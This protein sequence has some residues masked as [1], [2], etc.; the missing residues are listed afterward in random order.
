MEV[1]KEVTFTRDKA[2][3]IV[4]RTVRTFLNNHEINRATALQGIE[5]RLSADF[6][7]HANAIKTS[8]LPSLSSKLGQACNL[9]IS[10][11]C[12]SNL[13]F[14]LLLLLL[15]LLI[16]TES[17]MSQ[18]VRSLHAFWI[19]DDSHDFRVL[20]GT[21][22]CEMQR[23][24]CVKTHF[25]VGSIFRVLGSLFSFIPFSGTDHT[26]AH[27]VMGSARICAREMITEYTDNGRE[28]IDDLIRWLGLTDLGVI[29]Y[30]WGKAAGEIS[31]LLNNCTEFVMLEPPGNYTK[32][33]QQ[34]MPVFKLSRLF[35]N[36]MSNVTTK[37]EGYPIFS[38][39]SPELL[40]QLHNYTAGLRKVLVEFY[41]DISIQWPV[42]ERYDTRPDGKFLDNFRRA[43]SLINTHLIS[44]QAKS[45]SAH[46]E[47][48][49]KYMTWYEDWE[50]L[51]F[52]AYNRFHSEY[53]DF[54][55]NSVEDS[56]SGESDSE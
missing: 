47:L 17:I 32:P 28:D 54:Y 25:K 4:I 3:E 39:M 56:S 37:N 24:R 36:K 26:T 2:R 19:R 6:E 5:G 33:L 38:E 30:E 18:I 51:F 15:K 27:Y 12:Q 43:L 44:L 45:P 48:Y 14:N 21:T 46:Q 7:I 16:Q 8:L 9:L 42:E 13:D 41:E 35:F 29:Q 55:V 10:I 22:G 40:L 20:E 34:M 49:Q 23:Y 53:S 50:V 52:V 31:V 1:G 11:Y